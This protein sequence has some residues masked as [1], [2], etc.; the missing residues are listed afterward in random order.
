MWNFAK[1]LA[2]VRG[3]PEREDLWAEGASR[4]G[5]AAAAGRVL[6]QLD[7]GPGNHLP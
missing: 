1:A 2:R 6:Y 3:R 4:R 7:P 5:R